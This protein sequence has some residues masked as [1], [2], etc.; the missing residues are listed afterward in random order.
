MVQGFSM[1]NFLTQNAIHQFGSDGSNSFFVVGYG[2]YCN[3]IV[4]ICFILFMLLV[5]IPHAISRSERSHKKY[6]FLWR[7]HETH[8][9]VGLP[10]VLLHAFNHD[11]PIYTNTTHDQ[12]IFMI[13]VLWKDHIIVC[14]EKKMYKKCV[15]NIW[16]ELSKWPSSI[17]KYSLH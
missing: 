16:Y 4:C 11:I 17:F 1:A 7:L 10:I 14:V 3:H 8:L 6:H 15:S 9:W 5:S 2:S 12:F 13:N